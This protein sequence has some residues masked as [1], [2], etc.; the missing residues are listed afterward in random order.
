MRMLLVA[1]GLCV[2]ANAWGE[3]YKTVLTLDFENAET[4]TSGW[5]QS[6]N[7]DATIDREAHGTGNALYLKANAKRGSTFTY[8]LS[9]LT[10]FTSASKYKMEFDFAMTGQ[11]AGNNAEAGVFIYSGSTLL[12]N[13]KSANTAWAQSLSITG[14]DTA[15]ELNRYDGTATPWIHVLLVGIEGDGIYATVTNTTSST[16]LVN[17]Q[18]I[19]DFAN[20][21]SFVA[22]TGRSNGKL[23]VD[24]IVC[25]I[26]LEAYTTRATAAKSTY[27]SINGQVMNST[28]K[29]TLD[30]AYN[31]LNTDFD[32]DEKIL[33]NLAG[34]ASAI[35]ALETANTNAQTSINDFQVLNDL[36]TNA[37]GIV[38]YVAPTG[39]ETVFTANA[40][41]NP[42]TLTAAVRAAIITA[43]TA[44]EDTDITAL[45]AN[46]SFELGN[47]NGWTTVA[48]DDTG[49][50]TVGES[51]STYYTS[52]ADGSYLFNTW[53]KGTPITQTLGTLPAGRYKL[54][55]KVSSNGATVYFTMNSE[56]STG[57][58]TSDG[59][60]FID[61]EYTFTLGSDQE[62]TIGL[63]GG[64]GS[65]NFTAEGHWWYKADKFTLTYLGEDP[66]EQAKIALNNEITAATTVK[67]NY[68]AKVGTAPFLYPIATY[69]TLVTELTEA[70]AVIDANGDVVS[71]YTTAQSELEA[72]KDAMNSASQIQPD[73]DKYYRIYMVDGGAKT[74]Y[75]LN[76]TKG[77]LKQQV[78]VTAA[79]YPVKIVAD[80]STGRWNIKTPY[81]NLMQTDN[82]LGITKAYTNGFDG[83]DGRCGSI[84]IELTN[85][86]FV[87]LHGYR[88][89]G[90]WYNYT[91]NSASEGAVVNANIGLNGVWTVSDAVDVDDVTLSV[92]A[93]AGWGT[94]IAPFDNLTPST[95]KAYTVSYKSGSTVFFEENTTGVLS[96]NTPYIL[97]TEEASDVSTT[98]TG[99]AN[100]T[101]DTYTVNGLVG[102]L[103]AGTVPANSYVLQYQAGVDGTAFY[104]VTS[105]MTGVANRCYLDLSAVSTEAPV[106]A[107]VAASFDIYDETTGINAI[108]N[109]MSTING[110]F[111]MQGQRV[112]TPQ[113]GLYIVN[114]KKV[115]IK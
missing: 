7:Y 55:A 44:N 112:A 95:V 56:H 35:S 27:S 2:G 70:K 17:N 47:T 50:R 110:A 115:I 39:A 32:T 91:A 48:S 81:G 24:D 60:V 93:T 52:G 94:F 77:V 66:L 102:L 63:V 99:I 92:N 88:M 98:L 114:G 113:K 86:G 30:A 73:P 79:P 15:I 12:F 59:A 111:N 75:N 20:I 96:A 43:G 46:S 100:N 78:S 57:T 101:N 62:V 38:G 65:G 34:Y 18:K 23:Y 31:T 9:S 104:K 84:W 103:T 10:T 14:Y 67:N 8:S 4:Y 53:S 109:E 3:D 40:D 106:G 11:G 1:A 85:E 68:T 71:A 69:N 42:V 36:I 64:D 54:T 80:G 49:A 105:D 82:K 87:V 19:A 58:V 5:T 107:R 13:A 97:S 28:V 29:S 25:T 74:A 16:T 108:N 37:A 45:I 90:T 76:L 83:A 33:A 89:S 26:D 51:G 22:Q 41:V 61:A 6:A 21:T 72:A